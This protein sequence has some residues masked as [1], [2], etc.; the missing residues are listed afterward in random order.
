[1]D[2]VDVTLRRGEVVGLVGESGC[3][4]S[5]LGRL[6]LRLLE[7]DAGTVFFEGTDLR[8]LAPE[9]LR[10][11]RSRMQLVHQSA[12]AALNPGMTV[13]THLRETMRLHR[14]E[15]RAIEDDVIDRI[16]ESFRLR[17]K[18]RSYPGDLSGG[19]LRRVGLARCLLP[20]PALVVAD[21]PTAGLDASVKSDVL[22]VLSAAIAEDTAFLFISHELDV[23]RWIADRVLVMH[24]GR[25]VQEMPADHLDPRRS[26]TDLHPYTARLLASGL[27]AAPRG[28]GSGA[29]S[30]A[31]SET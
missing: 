6:L 29:L 25:I 30:S 21:E 24:E 12:P 28:S 20:Q 10:K 15:D 9:P 27:D 14:P 16:L 26:D 4:K 17:G 22:A 11:L 23:V 7:V 13:E 19:E 3:G 31:R 5:T 18:R 1:V 8:A 2:G